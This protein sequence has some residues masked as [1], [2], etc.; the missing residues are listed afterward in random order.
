MDTIV[1]LTRYGQRVIAAQTP[2]VV[3]TTNGGRV[4]GIT[5][6]PTWEYRRTV[7]EYGASIPQGLLIDT[8]ACLVA[9]GA[10]VESVA[11]AA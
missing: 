3:T 10:P 1:K 5:V 9:V 7:G 11:A 6:R 8:G 4:A 2:V